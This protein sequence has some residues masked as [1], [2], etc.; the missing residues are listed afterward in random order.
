MSRES[1][2]TIVGLI[3]GILSTLAPQEMRC[4]F[5]PFTSSCFRCL[6]DSNPPYKGSLTT[7]LSMLSIIIVFGFV[8]CILDPEVGNPKTSLFERELGLTAMFL[9]P[10][11]LI[12]LISI[13][14]LE[15]CL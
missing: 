3:L 6:Q 11:L 10:S 15:K 4:I 2:I 13:Y 5:L 1:R 8:Y 14:Q 7:A 9:F 12:L